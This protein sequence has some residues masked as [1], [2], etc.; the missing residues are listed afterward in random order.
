[1]A[2]RIATLPIPNPG[3]EYLLEAAAI[4]KVLYATD[5][6][7]L[8]VKEVAKLRTAMLKALWG[9]GRTLRNV[10]AAFVFTT[11]KSH[12]FDPDQAFIYHQLVIARKVLG[13]SR[14][15][16][17]QANL[18]WET[19]D[20]LSNSGPIATLKRT[21][22]RLGWEKL[23][24]NFNFKR[25]DDTNLGL[26][27]GSDTWWKHELRR[28]LRK[29]V[30]SHVPATRVDLGMLASS[31]NINRRAST[32]WLQPPRGDRRLKD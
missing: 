14:H 25:P 29:F 17:A 7:S 16:R 8:P 31:Q 9:P 12:R 2:Q 15:L 11:E 26:F 30:L 22:S 27:G 28:S 18:I 23:D 1:M 3:K 21:C 32:V 5:A 20:D 19:C 6:K 13:N 4:S 24:D 10:D